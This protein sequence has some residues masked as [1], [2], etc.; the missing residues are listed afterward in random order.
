[1]RQALRLSVRDLGYNWQASLCFVAAL[2]GIL[3]PLLIVFA[4]KNGIVTTMLG[5]LVDDP[6]NRELIAIGARSH[7]A[8]FFERIGA[9]PDVAF[10]TPATR[11]IN[12]Q[13]NAVRHRAAR[14][15]ELKVVLIPSA[16]GD[17]LSPAAEVAPGEVVLSKALAEALEAV[18]GDT[19]E[20]R[21]ERRLG[22]R[23]ETATRDL[24]VA[25]LVPETLYSRPAMFI[26]LPDL[27][28]VERF[29]DDRTISLEDWS[30]ERPLPARYASFRLYAR[31]LGD[32]EGLEAALASE[33]VETRPRARNVALLLA[34]RRNVDLLFTAVALL[35][36][37][38]FWAA[39]AANL[40]GAV[41]R[42]RRSLSLLRLLGLAEYG[43]RLIPAIQSVVLV[44]AGVGVSL[45]LVLPALVFVNRNFTPE[46]M[47]RIAWLGAGHVLGTV[48]LGLVT[49]VTASLWA[50]HAVK[51]ITSDE[52]LRSS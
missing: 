44:L 47:D 49:A 4:L 21:I 28:A 39:M 50:V 6:S 42:Q 45:V 14:R 27:M 46:G 23:P 5:Q 29:R 22:D 16:P 7:D 32:V 17:P 26:S 31:A 48:A 43:R 9:R 15:L 35:A 2:V 33:G 25:G 37:A 3:A 30:V 40:R 10:L 19:V 52:V 8:A 11:S 12:A 36:L 51:E 34:F 1:M 24:R 20:M 13:A 18:P 41:E 38:G